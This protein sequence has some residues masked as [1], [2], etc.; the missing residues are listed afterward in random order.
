MLL[1]CRYLI[2]FL[3]CV[4]IGFNRKG[5]AEVC[6]AVKGSDGTGENFIDRR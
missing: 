3:V 4:S 1:T 2:R 6:A 5:F